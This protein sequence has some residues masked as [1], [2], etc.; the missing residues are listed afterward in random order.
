MLIEGRHFRLDWTSPEALGR[1][2]MRVN[3]SDIAAMGGTPRFAL[4]SLGLPRELKT[5]TV[6]RIFRGLE[7]ELTAEGGRV[8]GGDTN[9]S[10]RLILNVALLGE[11]GPYKTRSGSRI[12]DS[13]YVTGSLGEA[14]LGLEL[15][16]KNEGQSS[17]AARRLVARHLLPPVRLKQGRFLARQ[18]NVHAVIDVSD[19][20]AGDLRHIVPGLGAV[21]ELENLPRSRDFLKTTSENAVFR[22]DPW[23]F[24]LSGGED[25]ELLFT[26]S[27]RLNLPRKIS[28][29]PIT[30]IGTVTPHAGRIEFR[31]GGR[32]L[33]KRYK[34][35]EHF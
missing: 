25:Y 11:A 22:K 12:G 35:F 33:A 2:A 1:K 29:V 27:A 6:A 14:A 20:L 3:L 13:I 21:I 31:L 30:K 10:D 19:G 24:A 8:I 34:G 18:K 17:P 5:D 15:F 4:V 16:K 28:G 7:R 9:L 23:A 32:P 26:A